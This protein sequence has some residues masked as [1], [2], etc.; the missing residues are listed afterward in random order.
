M[1]N[2]K[3]KKDIAEIVNFIERHIYKD[4]IISIVRKRGSYNLDNLSIIEMKAVMSIKHKIL[5]KGW[6]FES[7]GIIMS[8]LSH[9]YSN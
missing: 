4:S 2:L 6:T 1:K 3:F 7:S 8:T 5:E 9:I